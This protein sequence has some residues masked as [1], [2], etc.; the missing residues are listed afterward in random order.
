[1]SP[2]ARHHN[3][4]TNIEAD[5]ARAERLLA[6]ALAEV[7]T[8]QQNRQAASDFEK[9]VRDIRF[10]LEN[11]WTLRRQHVGQAATQGPLGFIR[12]EGTDFDFKPFA[13]VPSR[14]GTSSL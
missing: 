4:L 7:A 11:L 2:I 3:T 6:D 12:T 13:G 8:R 10:E 5:V 1:M 14:P 9:R